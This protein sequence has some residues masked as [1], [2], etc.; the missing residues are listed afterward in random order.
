MIYEVHTNITECTT[1]VCILTGGSN[2]SLEIRLLSIRHPANADVFP[3]VASLRR[4]ITSFL[5]SAETSDSRKYVCAR[6]TRTAASGKLK[7]TILIDLIHKMA[8][9]LLID[10]NI[11]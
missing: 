6:R 7:Y 3:A 2:P 10:F 8:A 1:S 11:C 5:F 9:D 4:K